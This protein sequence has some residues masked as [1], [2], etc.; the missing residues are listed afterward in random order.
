M[1]DVNVFVPA[2]LVA[3]RPSGGLISPALDGEWQLVMSRHL[4]A[5]LRK[6]FGYERI[7]PAATCGTDEWLRLRP[8]GCSRGRARC[9]G[10]A[11]SRD[12]RPER[13]LMALA[14]SASVDAIISG[15]DDLLVL[16]DL[17][18]P[19]LRPADFLA[20]LNEGP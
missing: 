18:P 1:A 11:G 19:V 2:A 17:I 10:A 6:V 15:D 20:M 3:Q 4:L 7:S 8:G 5:E 9:P 16:T 14:R 13:Y 12:P